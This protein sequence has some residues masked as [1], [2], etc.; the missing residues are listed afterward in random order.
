MSKE[1]SI[2][3]EFRQRYFSEHFDAIVGAI[4]DGVKVPGYFA[5]SLMDNLEWSAGYGIR[6]G[7]TFTDYETLERTP[8]NSA[9]MIQDILKERMVTKA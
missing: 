2:K 7:V 3:D 1:E 5:W 6:F 8:K 4:Q 9:L